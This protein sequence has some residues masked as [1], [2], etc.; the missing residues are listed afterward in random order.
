MKTKWLQLRVA[1]DYHARVK[2]WATALGMSVS[3]FVIKAIDAFIEN[4]EMK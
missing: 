3:Q 1:V 4:E 2:L